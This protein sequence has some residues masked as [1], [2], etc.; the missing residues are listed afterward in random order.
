MA[1][2]QFGLVQFREKCLLLC[3]CVILLHML[4]ALLLLWDCN[5]LSSY[6]LRLLAL[7]RQA[8]DLVTS[9]GSFIDVRRL[10]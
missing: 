8:S 6:A 2:W 7:E 9:C 1:H 5:G 10:S 4:R 3:A